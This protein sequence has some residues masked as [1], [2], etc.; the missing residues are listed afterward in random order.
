M[1]VRTIADVNYVSNKCKE[2]ENFISFIE[3]KCKVE[4]VGDRAD[5]SSSK[6]Y[7]DCVGKSIVEVN[8]HFSAWKREILKDYKDQLNKL[9]IGVKLF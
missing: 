7:K 4:L 5:L 8:E 2:M 6:P 1:K 9:G 3:E